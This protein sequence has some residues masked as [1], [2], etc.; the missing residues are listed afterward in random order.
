MVNVRLKAESMNCPHCGH[1]TVQGNARVR[2][3]LIGFMV[4]GFSFQHLYFEK[5]EDAQM[6]LM[7]RE[8]R[9][10][11]FCPSCG[12]LIVPGPGVIVEGTSDNESALDRDKRRL[13]MEAKQCTKCGAIVNPATGEGIATSEEKQWELHCAKCGALVE[14]NL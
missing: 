4:V 11:F 13:A 5:G 7:S 6:I 1:E 12:T 8:E 2:G 14:P 9:R 3:N 10:S